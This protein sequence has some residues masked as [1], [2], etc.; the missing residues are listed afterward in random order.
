MR[1]RR[2]STA[3]DHLE[4]R[5]VVLLR[6]GLGRLLA[7]L[8]REPARLWNGWPDRPRGLRGRRGRR[9][10]RERHVRRGRHR[11]QLRPR[12]LDLGQVHLRHPR[13]R[14]PVAGRLMTLVVGRLVLV[15][16]LVPGRLAREMRDRER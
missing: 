16:V 5:V 12:E 15:R 10:G 13:A 8:G 2:R 6:H 11:R 9:V 14:V 7:G 3:S 1:D 4:E